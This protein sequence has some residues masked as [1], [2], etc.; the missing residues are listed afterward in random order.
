MAGTVERG[1][2]Y[3]RQE[4]QPF[5]QAREVVASGGEDGVGGVALGSGEV[6]SAHA[7]LGF[8]VSDDRFDRGAAAQLAFDGLGDATSLARDIDLKLVFGRGVVAAIAAVGDDAGEVG[9]DLGL[10]LRDHGGE[11]VTVVGVAGQRL[12]MGDELTTLGAIERGGERHL[13]PELV[14]AMGFSLANAFD[15]GRVQGIDLPS[16]LML[17][18]ARAP[19]GRA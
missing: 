13:D 11:R 15:L 1:Q 17:G 6:V 12:G 10:D 3:G 8:G 2:D 5:E 14:G 9:A 7:M 18:A 19:D 4:S 16:A